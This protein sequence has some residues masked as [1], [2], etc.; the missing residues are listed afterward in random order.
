MF[1]SAK[2]IGG[3]LGS[4]LLAFPLLAEPLQ[5]KLGRTATDK[6]IAGWDISIGPDG[7]NLPEAKGTVPQGEKLYQTNALTAMENLERPLDDGPF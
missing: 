3:F 6:E 7:S 5:Y 4:L 2:F 1:N